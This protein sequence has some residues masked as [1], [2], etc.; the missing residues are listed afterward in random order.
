MKGSHLWLATLVTM[1]AGCPG[2]TPSG[3]PVSPVSQPAVPDSAAVS[4]TTKLQVGV[5]TSLSGEG[6][7]YGEYTRNG[8]ELA[9]GEVEGDDF[10]LVYKDTKLDP[11]EAVRVFRELANAGVSIVI[12]PFSSSE[13]RVVGPKAQEA[14]VV[15]LSTSATADDLSSIGDHIFMMLPPNSQQG[16]DQATFAFSRLG[17]RRASILYRENPYG[18]TLRTA[19]KRKFEE[20][21][22]A[23]VTDL[24]FPDGHQEFGSRLDEIRAAGPQVVFLPC[25]DDDT[26]RILRQAAG[27]GFDAGIRFLGGDGSMSDTM[28]Q[29]GGDAA[30]GS[31]YSNVAS[32]LDSFD[33]TYER[34]H[35]RKPSPYA[36][37][38]YD[39][40]KIVA[41]LAA[42][43]AT[44]AKDFRNGLAG[45]SGFT[46][47][48][49]R[50]A[51]TQVDGGSYWALSKSYSQFEVRG[52]AFQVLR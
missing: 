6:A 43:G 42:G 22:G 11:E 5:L 7:S 44:T 30:E 40:Y 21:G 31:I 16:S 39:A 33:A 8:I 4:T 36:A 24:S 45:L 38:A 29:L 18:Q 20:L 28:L 47:A 2:E 10:E 35:G 12:G 23:I 13:V 32:V 19:F 1:F 25:H 37:A 49:G 52:G 26:G 34:A 14:G 51:F 50:T 15:L 46:G 48:T 9:R 3:G 41:Q 17:A 27:R